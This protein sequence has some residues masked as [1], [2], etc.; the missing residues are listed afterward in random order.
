MISGGEIFIVVLAILLFFGANKIPEFA[1]M[2]GKGVREFRKATDDIK[3]ELND[4]SS[5][6]MDD[7]K[8]IRDDISGTLNKEIA[9]PVEDTVNETA[10]MVEEE[11]SD[12][13]D[14]DYYYQNKDYDNAQGN[15]YATAAA[16]ENPAGG[17]VE[18]VQPAEG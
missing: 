17:N 13:Y 18:P 11:Y 5:G 12:P 3:R 8:A 15:E 9:A 4:S 10:A 16:E 6:V 7:V 14:H 2:M 1:R